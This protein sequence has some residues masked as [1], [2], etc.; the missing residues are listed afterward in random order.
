MITSEEFL[1][2]YE[3]VTQDCILEFDRSLIHKY[4]SILGNIKHL[5]VFYIKNTFQRW[6]GEGFD[7]HGKTLLRI[8]EVGAPASA[9]PHIFAVKVGK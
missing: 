8:E 9:S 5:I 2:K 6:R 3:K 7:G 1:E 4:I